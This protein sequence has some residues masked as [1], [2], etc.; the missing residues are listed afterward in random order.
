MAYE[1][2][3]CVLKQVKKGFTADGGAL[4]GAIYCERL[5][6]T[7]TVLPRL[8]GVAPLSDGRYALVLRIEG[9]DFCFSLQG[10]TALHA[11]NVPSIKSGFSALLCYVRGEAEPV[12]FGNCGAAAETPS[13]LLASLGGEKRPPV[14]TPP[15]QPVAPPAPNV[16]PAP[17]FPVPVP[18]REEGAYD[19]EAIAADNYF[20][21]PVSDET[22]SP[23]K[24]E[25]TDGEEEEG[26]ESTHAHEDALL[27][28]RGSLTYYKEVR[29]KLEAVMRQYPS[30]TRLKGAFPHSEWVRSPSALLG[31]IYEEGTPRYLCVAVEG[32][33]PED[34]KAN[35]CFVPIGPFS[36]EGFTVVFQDADT[37]AYVKVYD[38]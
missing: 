37:G 4:Q 31:I 14:P 15:V 5:G 13:S 24:G 12:A 26:E 20:S 9:K 17:S 8:L 10:S 1:K 3:V 2:R 32:D 38:T 36:K 35:G 27:F 19:D 7:L 6:E 29:E 11:E 30:D 18:F 16:P 25:G 21:R 33:P 22:S 28:T 23:P 34:V